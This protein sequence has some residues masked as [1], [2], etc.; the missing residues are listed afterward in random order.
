MK[1]KISFIIN[2][3]SGSGKQKLVEKAVSKYLD[4]DFE[5]EILYT[6]A[7][8]HAIELSQKASKYADIVVAVG[9]DGSINEVAQGLI[10]TDIP[11][12]IIPRGSG[13][14]LA[15]FLKI[16]LDIAKAIEL[17]KKGKSK[18]IDS[19]NIDKELS[20][21]VSGIGFDAHIAHLFSQSKKRGLSSYIRII[22]QEFLKYKA[23][24]YELEIENKT[25]KTKAFLISFA[26]SSQFG[27]NAH[28]APKAIIDDGFFEVC[29]LKPF[30]KFKTLGIITRLFFKNIHQSKY[31][32]T[33]K[34]KSLVLKSDKEIIAHIDGEAATLKK[35][36]NISINPL[37]LNIIIP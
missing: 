20:V 24:T 13:N 17:I 16:P 26:N 32:E 12:G 8:K 4:D 9:G 22:R 23:E 30:P 18:K 37:S 19:L 34:T 35:E 15:R 6:K 33:I 3:I 2:P 27:N 7:A 29:I 11:M 25:F 21:N 14:G 5:I 28:I 1:K 36:I 10:G 31:L